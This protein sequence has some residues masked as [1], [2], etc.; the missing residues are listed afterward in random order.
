VGAAWSFAKCDLQLN[1]RKLSYFGVVTS[2]HVT[3]AVYESR[4]PYNRLIPIR[5]AMRETKVH[6][7]VRVNSTTGKAGWSILGLFRQSLPNL[8]VVTP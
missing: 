5:F 7:V 8:V 3:L 1:Y 6:M 2:N 4:L